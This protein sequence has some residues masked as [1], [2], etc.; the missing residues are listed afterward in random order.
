MKFDIAFTSTLERAWRTCA[1]VLS[2]CGQS[3]VETIK[4]WR[5]NERH[6][7]GMCI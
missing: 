1:L 4:S 3:D 5:L 6:Y 7:G 2:A